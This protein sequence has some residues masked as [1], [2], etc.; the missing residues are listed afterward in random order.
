ME[1][2]GIVLWGYGMKTRELQWLAFA[3]VIQ[4]G[5]LHLWAAIS[6]P[7]M[8][9][10]LHTFFVAGFMAT[11]VAALGLL[12][13]RRWAWVMGILIALGFAAAN[14][15]VYTVG[16][17]G[18]ARQAWGDPVD[19]LAFIMD[20][21]FLGIALWWLFGARPALAGARSSPYAGAEDAFV[22]TGE[23]AAPQSG[24]MAVPPVLYPISAA[25]FVLL[26]TSIA[27]RYDTRA[28]PV[29]MA[30]AKTSPIST[31]SAQTFADDYGISVNRVAVTTMGGVVDLRLQILDITK[32]RALLEDDSKHPAMWIGDQSLPTALIPNVDEICGEDGT[33]SFSPQN[34]RALIMPAHMSHSD[35]NLRDGGMYIMFYPNPQNTVR[36]GTP[37]SLFF[38]KTRVGPIIVQ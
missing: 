3:L 21:S 16:L 30:E 24:A 13:G 29:F 12:R 10:A 28:M 34:P 27:L 11:L 5:L 15:A 19:T 23:L 9:P 20:I 7:T 26:L 18:M 32:A 25:V 17:P 1:S 36:S 35:R 31:I 6:R 2:S 22:G 4:S 14:A 38:G 37:V 33:F 8:M